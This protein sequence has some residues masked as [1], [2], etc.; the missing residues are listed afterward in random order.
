MADDAI[1]WSFRRDDVVQVGLFLAATLVFAVVS[2]WLWSVEDSS[3][4]LLVLL[5]T[6]VCAAGGAALGL[7]LASVRLL[8]GRRT[9]V[10]GVEARPVPV[11]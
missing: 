11:R 2:V 1:R 9:E 6:T 4:R 7:V 8:H 3:R 10:R 5:F